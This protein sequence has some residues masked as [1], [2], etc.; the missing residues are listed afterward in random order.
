MGGRIVVSMNVEGDLTRKGDI[1][2]ALFVT[3]L[4]EFLT[5]IHTECEALQ[6]PQ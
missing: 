4:T 1:S 5:V 6:W 2:I 3:I